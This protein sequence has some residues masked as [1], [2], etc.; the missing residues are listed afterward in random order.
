LLFSEENVKTQVQRICFQAFCLA[1]AMIGLNARGQSIPSVKTGN[2]EFGL[3]G[4]ESYGLDRFR[5][6]GGAN[7]A[8]GLS[9]HLFPFFEASYLPGIVRRENVTTASTTS[10]R[11]YNVNMTDFHGGL[12]YRFLRPESHVVPYVV[13]GLGLLRGSQS[14]ATLYNID[15]YGGVHP[16]TYPVASSVNFAFNFGGGLRFFLSERFA[17]RVEF[18][19][20]KPTSAPPPLQP[21][22]FYRF[23]LGPVFQVR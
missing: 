4:G 6:M 9:G 1:V 5:P 22:I 13:G 16:Q 14:T 7:V 15:I 8:Y 18:K 11:Q 12:H 20:F 2:L 10:A 3:F 19:A 21:H 23:A 17:V